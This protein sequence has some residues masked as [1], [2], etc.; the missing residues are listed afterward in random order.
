MYYVSGC[1]HGFASTVVVYVTTP[2]EWF[3]LGYDERRERIETMLKRPDQSRKAASPQFEIRGMLPGQFPTVTSFLMDGLYEDGTARRTATL[4]IFQNEQGALGATM[5]DRDNS[6]ALFGA[7]DSLESVL[8]NLEAQLN[9]PQPPWRNDRAKAG[10][11]RR[12]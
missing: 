6:R 5:N 3:R 11:A 2:A 10:N 12:Q 9:Q 4:T 8:A 7:G 1:K